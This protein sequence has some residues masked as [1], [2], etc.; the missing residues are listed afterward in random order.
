MKTF[1]TSI[2]VPAKS[3]KEINLQEAIMLSH[4]L[5]TPVSL[6]ELSH[7]SLDEVQE[8]EEFILV[9]NGEYQKHEIKMKAVGKVAGKMRLL[10]SEPEKDEVKRLAEWRFKDAHLSTIKNALYYQL[11]NFTIHDL[12]RLIRHAI[13]NSE[14]Q[15]VSYR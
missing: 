13:G 6:P 3:K 4:R 2:F 15:L 9:V 10:F 5:N 7:G 8:G 14:K 1:T 12:R 11:K